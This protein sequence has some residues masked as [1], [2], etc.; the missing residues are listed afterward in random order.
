MVLGDKN[1]DDDSQIVWVFV[2]GASASKQMFRAHAEEMKK[3]FG[4]SSI[5]VDLPGHA[6]LVDTPLTLESCVTTMESVLKE[7]ESWTKGQKL[8]YVGGSL[9]AYIG[10]YLVDKLQDRFVGAVLMDCGQNVG[11]GASYKARAGLVVLKWIGSHC[12]NATLMKLMLGE[13]KKSRADFHLMDTVFA[14]GMFF[15]QADAHVECLRAVAPADYIPNIPFPI[16]FMNGSEDYRDSETKWLELCRNKEASELKVYEGGDHFF[17]H[18]TRFVED[19]FNRW[20][21]FAKKL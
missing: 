2:H 16:L 20:E 11:P 15:D 10:F 3:R 13:T 1:N 5:L 14:A 21:A 19:V 17:M 4:H 18:D 9:G 6:S 12:S 7:C 8:I